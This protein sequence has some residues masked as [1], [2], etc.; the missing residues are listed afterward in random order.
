TGSGNFSAVKNVEVLSPSSVKFN[1]ARPFSALPS[2]LAY[3][4]GIL[5]KHSFDGQGNPWALNAFN[6][7]MPV[8]SGPFKVESYTSGQGVTLVRNDAYC[9][10]KANLDKI[11][12]KVVPDAN[13]QIA[14]ALS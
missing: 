13:T 6:K 3:N 10:G 2:Y 1:L 9:G 4:A 5:P 7:G 14:Q 8:S 11:V 12:F